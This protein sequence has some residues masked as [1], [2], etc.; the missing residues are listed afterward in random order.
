[1]RIYRVLLTPWVATPRSARWLFLFVL[2]LLALG[3]VL[4]HIF[5]I[6]QQTWAFNAVVIGVAN[7]LCW[8]LLLPNGLLLAMTARRLRVP[9]IN[10][11]AVWSLPLY[12]ALGIG[13]PM[14]FQ[15]QQGHVLEFA[16]VQV[17]VAVGAMLFMVLPYYFVMALYLLVVISHRALNHF[18]SIPGLFD[19]RFVLWG[20]TAGVVALAVLAW[21]WRQVLRGGCRERGL[22]APGMVFFQRNLSRA[23]S[24]PLTDAGSM[25]I[26][27]DWLLARPNLHNVGPHRPTKSLRMALGGVYLPQTI[28][29]YLHQWAFVVLSLTLMGLVFFGV[30]FGDHSVSGALHYVFSHDGFVAASW[31]FAVFALASVMQPVELLT[32]RWGRVNSELPLLALLPRLGRAGRS[33][34]LLL[35]TVIEPPA[36]RLGLLLVLGWLGVASLHVG[37]P[38]ALAMLV[39]ALGCLSYLYAMALS[40]FGGRPLNGFGK[41][42]LLLCMF[43]VLS[44]TVLLPQLGDGLAAP[45]VARAG[46]A[47][48]VA[49]LA[50]AVFL[51]WLAR[52]GGC[53][54]HQR[55]HPF[56]AH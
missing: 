3:A 30:T 27:P 56:L 26:R 16:I 12:A 24:D 5:G 33:K 50:L 43:V 28:I 8:L 19:P 25:R 47:L 1:M 36:A 13:V 23:Q 37:W 41:S 9:G 55:P 39:V 20:S 18:I 48:M 6:A 17:L 40:I 42:L 44:A 22:G 51:W 11:D 52:R 10:R 31:M 49:W 54:L 32:L 46:G 53:A 34:R 29:G 38:V 7:A 2:T 15:F 4:G 45:L 21:R 35:R 14:L